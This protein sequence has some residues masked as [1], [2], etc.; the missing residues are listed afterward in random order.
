MLCKDISAKECLQ[1]V[2]EVAVSETPFDAETLK[3]LAHPLRIKIYDH[4]STYGS[5]TSTQL[6]ELLG[7]NTG[8]TSYHLRILAR[9]GLIEDDDQVEAKGRE[10]WWRAAHAVR[11]EPEVLTDPG[12]RAASKV[13]LSAVAQERAESLER[14]FRA[15]PDSGQW[16]ENNI[17]SRATVQ[18]RPEDARKLIDQ[19]LELIDKI[20]AGYADVEGED[21]QRV[22]IYFDV[23]PLLKDR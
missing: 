13:V 3:A 19:V 8:Q 12:S 9:H 10:R 2:G 20:T 21:A 14:W 15:A 23:F 6:A 1:E 18:L 16:L 22:R 17:T 4:L 7:E 11:M 5:A